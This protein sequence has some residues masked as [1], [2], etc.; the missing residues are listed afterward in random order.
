MARTACAKARA[1]RSPIAHR[2]PKKA[3]AVKARAAGASAT[4]VLRTARRKASPEPVTCVH[5]EAGR[6]LAFHGRDSARG[7]RRIPGATALRVARSRLPDDPGRYALS[8]CQSRRGDFVDHR[9]ARAAV[10]ANA[11]TGADVVDEL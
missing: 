4:A 5:P 11:G 1:Y 8:R 2:A 6:D 9:S 3:V 10:R 7:H